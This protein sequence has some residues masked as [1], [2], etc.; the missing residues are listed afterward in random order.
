MLLRVDRRL[1]SVNKVAA[2]GQH[3]RCRKADRKLLVVSKGADRRPSCSCHRYA[4]ARER[5]IRCC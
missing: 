4:G 2:S 1:S 3:S 5:L